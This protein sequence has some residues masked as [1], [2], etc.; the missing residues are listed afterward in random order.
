MSK[1]AVSRAQDDSTFIT[2]EYTTNYTFRVYTQ[3]DQQINSF[4]SNP[5]P[6]LY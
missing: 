6:Y 3:D 1:G 4:M 2:A 5:I